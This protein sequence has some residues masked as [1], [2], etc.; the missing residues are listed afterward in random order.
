M[1]HRRTAAVRGRIRQRRSGIRCGRASWAQGCDMRCWGLAEF[2]FPWAEA[3][4]ASRVLA[5]LKTAH[6]QR[7]FDQVSKLVSLRYRR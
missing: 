1:W 6:A 5:V 2:A 3:A 4:S 7:E